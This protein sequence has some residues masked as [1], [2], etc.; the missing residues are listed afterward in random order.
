MNTKVIAIINHK[1]GVGKT[2]T[3]TGIASA[4]TQ[5]EPNKKI[6][7]I[8]ADEQA[9]LKTVFG[10][11]LREAEAS[12]ASILTADVNPNRSVIKVREN[13]DVIIS[14]GREIRDFNNRFS[15]MPESEEIMSKRFKNLEGYDYVLI[16]CP[17]A[18]SLISS[19]IVLYATH[20]IIPVAPDMLSQMAAKATITFLDEMESRFGK[21]AKILGVLPTMH[22]GRRNI[23]LDV[24]EDLE[25]LADS[26]LLKGGRCFHEIRVDS[27]VKTSQVKRKLIHE[28]FPK[29]NAGKDFID[30]TKEIL[31][32]LK[33]EEA[34][35]RSKAST[36]GNELTI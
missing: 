29:S 30:A 32:E 27:K 5:L 16:D 7:L 18:L 31:D 1:G 28:T 22:D 4:I 23:D 10:I 6:L 34:T 12:L 3:T 35:L 11:K 21:S 36:T 26:D 9:N 20:V 15:S 13:I 8:D 33:R 19:N 2:A 24:L 14:G 17:P 25:R